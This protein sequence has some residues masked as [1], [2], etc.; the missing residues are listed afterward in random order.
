[1]HLTAS[2]FYGGPERQM[3]GLGHSLPPE[4]RTI[5]SSFSEKGRSRAFMDEVRRQ[6]FEAAPLRHDTP[7]LRAAARELEGHIRRSGVDFLCCHTY[8]ADLVG[9]VAARR[10]G[11][12]VV[13]VSR[14]WTSATLKLRLYEA[15]DRLALR[16]MD[17]VICVSEGQAVQVRRAG[18]VPERIMVIRNAIF[19]ERFERP[20]P[21]FGQRLRAF[22][23]RPPGRIVGAAGRLSPEKGFHLLIRAARHVL[24]DDPSL[25]FILFG[26][27]PL[28]AKL[29]RKID[30][31]GLAGKFVL[32]GFRSDLDFFLPF[33]DLL[34]LP[35]Y[36]EGLPNVVLEAFAAGVPV[37]AT[38]VGGTPEILEDGL[39]GYLVPPG[40]AE[41]LRRRIADVLRS[42]ATR[43][44][45]GARGRDRVRREF[46]FEAQSSRYQ[47][48]FH[49]LTG[50]RRPPR[51]PAGLLVPQQ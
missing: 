27:G 42:E 22:F 40:D 44:A 25:G 37:V 13:A 15:L 6:G 18:V 23:P 24:R 49:E 12:P 19:R 4:Y 38:A 11:I 30:R 17:R 10:C 5:F 29:A 35:S 51:A 34:V 2:T 41:V 8:K 16:W 9:R 21:G 33:F 1:M 45:M 47:E 26:D 31:A 28:R 7:F 20:D 39:S 36:N 3:C 48:L 50:L 43:R 14:G 32:G 46:S